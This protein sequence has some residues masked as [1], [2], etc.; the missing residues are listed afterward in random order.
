MSSTGPYST[1]FAAE[2]HEHVVGDL[3]DHAQV[4]RDEQDRHAALVA[5]LAEDVE[6]L[7]LD[8]D[9]ERGRRL[10]GDQQLADCTT[11][12]SRSSRA[13]SGRRTSGAD[14]NRRAA[15][16]S[17][18]PTSSKQLD[19]PLAGLGLGHL[20]VQQD[21]LHHLI[22][23]GEDRVERRHRLLKDHADLFAA[24][25]PHLRLGQPHEV[26]AEERDAARFDLAPTRRAAA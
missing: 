13:A 1:I 24:D 10:V 9:V 16:G 14:T 25:R 12:P 15:P 21:R 11:G 3:G 23:D 20:L 5:E 2:H 26:A 4:V 22:A 6:D 18:M 8:R 19:R 17:G 7:G